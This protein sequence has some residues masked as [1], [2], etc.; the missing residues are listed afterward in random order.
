MSK[1]RSRRAADQL[2]SKIPFD[3]QRF[4]QG[5]P[6]IVILHRHCFQ[7]TEIKSMAVSFLADGKSTLLESY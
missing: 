5:R 2:V 4:V 6:K 3:M 7:T 1:E